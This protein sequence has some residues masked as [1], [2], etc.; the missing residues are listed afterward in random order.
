[1]NEVTSASPSDLVASLRARRGVLV[2]DGWGGR[3]YQPV[4]IEGET[5]KK[6]RVRAVEEKL[7]LPLRGNGV[8]IILRS[9]TVLVPKHAVRVDATNV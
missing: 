4:I 7:R 8:R 1:M 2:I 3:S 9:G 5:P 6:Y